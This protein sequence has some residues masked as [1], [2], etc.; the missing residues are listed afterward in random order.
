MKPYIHAKSSAKKYGG[1]PEDYLDIHDFMD[2]SKAALPDV[3]HR[4]IL[5][6]AFGCFVV[7]KTFG[8][9]RTN[10]AGK[11]YSTRDIAE[12]H[13]IEDLGFIPT[14]EQ[15]FNTMEIQPWMGGPASKKE[16]EKRK[17]LT[18]EARGGKSRISPPITVREYDD[19][20]PRGGGFNIDGFKNN[21]L[22]A[23][24]PKK[25]PS[26]NTD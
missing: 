18:E 22:F 13:C 9:T 3:R 11:V 2:S 26:S 15:W 10:S 7:E 24:G 20:T 6:S 8:T 1:Q 25:I 23:D 12:D 4:A 17:A 19:G 16:R 14:V 21:G 5:H